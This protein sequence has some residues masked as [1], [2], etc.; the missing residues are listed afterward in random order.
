MI[1]FSNAKINLGLNITAKRN[2]GFHNLETIF[3]PINYK[4]IIEILPK[5]D[6][7]KNQIQFNCT[8]L[9]VSGTQENNLCVKAYNL[10]VQHIGEL[11]SINM[12]LHKQ[13]PMGAGLGG[14]SA[15]GSEVLKM[16]AQLFKLD[17]SN[18]TLINLSLQLGSDCPF[19]IINKPCF[20]TSRGEVL[21]PLSL[22]QLKDYNAVLVN[23]KIHINTG[24]AFSNITPKP[25]AYN[26]KNIDKQHIEVWQQL[27]VNDFE[28]PVFNHY[29]EIENI[30]AT[31]KNNG[32]I[33]ASLT[34]T[35]STVF[36]L[37]HIK[38]D[39]INFKSLFPENYFVEV[40]N[41]IEI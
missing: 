6:G 36:G 19:F 11:P 8:G 10:L 32:C 1:A 29:P 16:L 5:H 31:L 35:G 15:N 4:D 3:L 20:A 37:K 12:H 18:E 22:P 25:S 2:D 21:E 40:V 23:P 34:G 26:F 33:Y 9:E 14:G 24:W 13:V 39:N 30:K 17:I 41:F 28:I 7:T 27:V 38:A